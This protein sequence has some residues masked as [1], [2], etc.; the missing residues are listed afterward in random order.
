MRLQNRS[1]ALTDTPLLSADHDAEDAVAWVLTQS[2]KFDLSKFSLSGHSAGGNLALATSSLNTSKISSV[3]CLYPKTNWVGPGKKQPNPN[4]RSGIVL[5][6]FLTKYFDTSY[7]LNEEDRLNPKASPILQDSNKFP[8]TV[9]IAT[10][11]AD[12]LYYDGKDFIEKL[13]RDGH[14]DAVFLKVEG[15]GHTFEKHPNCKISEDR[16]KETYEAMAEAIKRGW[17]K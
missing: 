14:Q 1:R 9:F 11:D 7:I 10:G 16:K 3:V 5:T 2:D 8:K 6:P 4:M 15:E 13:Q 12:L 17:G